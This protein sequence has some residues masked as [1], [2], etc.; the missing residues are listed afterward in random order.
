[1]K[2]LINNIA[3]QVPDGL[4]VMEACRYAGVKIPSLCYLKDVSANASCGVCVVEVNGSRNLLRSCVTKATEGMEITT[5]SARIRAARKMNVELLL[6]N[7]PD[8]C[9][10]CDRNQNCELQ[11]IAYEFGIRERRFPRTKPV[12][13]AQDCSS[14]SLVRD[15]DK[16][17]LCGRVANG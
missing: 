14:L 1:M 15:P 13:Q 2:L 8:N 12:L 16:C 9:L 7:H 4:T 10:T 17:I 3:T 11:S 5:Q 6:A